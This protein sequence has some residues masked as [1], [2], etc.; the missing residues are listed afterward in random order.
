[1]KAI[2]AVEYLCLSCGVQ[3]LEVARGTVPE[4]R[5]TS[6]GREGTFKVLRCPRCGAPVLTVSVRPG[7]LATAV[8]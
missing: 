1:M 5:G 4:E 3:G 6:E 2:D 7:W 8:T